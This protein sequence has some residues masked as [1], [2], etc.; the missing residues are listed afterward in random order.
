MIL[1]LKFIASL[2]NITILSSG[3]AKV[4]KLETPP[5]L[6]A[7][8]PKLIEYYHSKSL[9]DTTNSYKFVDIR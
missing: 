4:M 8:L 6:N 5:S 9:S 3:E 1:K 2:L 7:P